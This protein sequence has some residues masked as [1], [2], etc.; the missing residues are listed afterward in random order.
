[1]HISMS[2][3]MS[4]SRFF[5]RVS[6][7]LL[8]LSVFF[9]VSR[10][11]QLVLNE[12]SQGQSGT[13]EFIELVVVGTKSCSDSCMDLRGWIFDDH[14]GW[15]GAAS[16]LG[17]ATGFMRFANDP[18]WACVP[19]GSIILIYNSAD[20]NTSITLAP[21]P[22]DANNDQVY[23]LPAN[24]SFI[25]TN[26]NQPVSPSSVSFIYPS[27]GFVANGNWSTIGMANSGDAVIIVDPLNP[28]VAH[29]SLTY[30]AV[31]GGTVHMSPSGAQVVYYVTGSQFN[32]A[33]GWTTG[34]SGS[35]NETPGFPNTTANNLWITSMQQGQ[36]TSPVVSILDTICQGEV[37]QFNGNAYT[38]SGTY[39]A[40]F[41]LPNGCD[42]TVTVK[43]WVTPTPSSLSLS[44]NNPVCERDT[45]KM[46]IQATPGIFYS[47]SGPSGWFATGGSASRA[48]MQQSDAGWY[49]VSGTFDG[50]IVRDSADIA[51]RVAPIVATRTDTTLCRGDNVLLPA[52]GA[53]SYQWA[54]PTSLSCVFCDSTIATPSTT[55]TFI[56][57]GTDV[58]G[59]KGYDTVTVLV[60]SVTA[61]FTLSTDTICG[62]QTITATSQ[63]SGSVAT[64]YWSFGNGITSMDVAPPVFTYADP[65]TY[66]VLFAVASA[67][68]CVDTF[69]SAATKV[70]FPTVGFN[71]VDPSLC[72]GEAAVFRS[73]FSSIDNVVWN[74][75]DGTLVEGIEDVIHAYD[76]S[77]SYVITATATNP[78]C[79]DTT[80]SQTMVVHPNPTVDIGN[81]TTLCLGGAPLLLRSSMFYSSAAYL[82]N[83]G[84]TTSEITARHPGRY[85]LKVT[86][87]WGCSASDSMDVFK[88]CYLDVP[89]AFTPNGDLLNDYFLPRQLLSLGTTLFSMEVYNRWGQKVF[90]TSDIYGRGWDGKFNGL[91]QPEGVYVYLIRVNF[92]GGFE[93]YDGNVTLL[94]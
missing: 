64:Y 86:T 57:E 71:L 43:L 1:M 53:A 17:I 31:L 90:E 13:K 18:N 10:A 24:S 19:Y 81:D 55:T 47:W 5:P 22:T 51:V 54:P 12:F 11:Q 29:F 94:R 25:E 76:T 36:T 23:V 33:A 4:V 30:G 59:C 70:S 37:Y 58:F 67:A 78:Y 40:I 32:N 35:A 26:P 85:A 82:W 68:G 44:A 27:T 2:S 48:P 77:G 79:P 69:I 8:F 66:P 39:S 91:D 28:G 88:N 80:Y 93:Q 87:E 75:G 50:C 52:T 3:M 42:S 73:S 46:N 9:S 14:N 34:T 65:G 38:T 61:L 16:G 92:G 56:V 62:P 63:A 83:T 84:D 7:L 49:Y 6:A 41:P 21:D 89:N 45:L 60:E 74:L 15:Y 20:V 72:E